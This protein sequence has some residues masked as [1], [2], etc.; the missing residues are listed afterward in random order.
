MIWDPVDAETMTAGIVQASCDKILGWPSVGL[1][2]S[3]H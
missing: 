2:H 3:N 1:W